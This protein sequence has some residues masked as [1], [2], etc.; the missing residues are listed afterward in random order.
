[1]P[2]FVKIPISSSEKVSKQKLDFGRSVC[3]S[4]ISFSVSIT[5]VLTNKQIFGEERTCLK[6]RIDNSRIEGLIRIYTDRHLDMAKYSS[7]SIRSPVL[8][9]RQT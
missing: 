7:Y 8:K 9:T 2:N 4:A 6:F 1:M 5:V 3:M